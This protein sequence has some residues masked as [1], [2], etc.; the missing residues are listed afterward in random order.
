MDEL[1][2]EYGKCLFEMECLQAK[3]NEIKRRLVEMYNE[4]SK[5]DVHNN[6]TK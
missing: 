1:Y 4:Q 3:L 6:A 2:A 5:K